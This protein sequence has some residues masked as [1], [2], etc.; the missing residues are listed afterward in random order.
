MNPLEFA[1]LARMIAAEARNLGFEVPTFRGRTTVEQRTIRYHHDGATVTINH[2]RPAGVVAADI[3]AGV[4]HYT[5]HRQVARTVDDYTKLSTMADWIVSDG[6][7]RQAVADT[8]PGVG[9]GAT[10][11]P[12]R[13]KRN[14]P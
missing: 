5:Q 4:I 13:Q 6:C 10:L 7:Y 3:V 12:Q 8:E 9:R 11:Q 2:T 14:T 1:H